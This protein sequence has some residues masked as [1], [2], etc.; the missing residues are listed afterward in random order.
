MTAQEG[1]QVSNTGGASGFNP[2]S[3]P[4]TPEIGLKVEKVRKN[5]YVL[6]TKYGLWEDRDL[7]GIL[8]IVEALFG[9]K[10]VKIVRQTL[11]E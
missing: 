3:V 5:K 9:K 7:A 4:Q 11:G 10:Y 1:N 2:Q 6:K 8:V